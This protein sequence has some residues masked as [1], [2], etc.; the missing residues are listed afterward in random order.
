MSF[1]N[2]MYNKGIT[3]C[4]LLFISLMIILFPLTAHGG[5]ESVRVALR[6]DQIFT[7]NSSITGLNSIF[8]YEL[9]ALEE[10]SPLPSGAVN[11]KYAF[12]LEDTV[13]KELDPITYNHAG[14]YRYELRMKTP[15]PERGY[16]YDTQVYSIAVYVKRGVT[17]WLAEVTIHQQ[18]GIKVDGLKFEHSYTPL[19]S[20]RDVMVDPPV[21]KTVTGNPLFADTFTF[22]LTAGDI[23]NPMPEG[24]VDGVKKITITG[25][26]EKDFG[27]WVYTRE[28][29]Y[30]YKI[31]EEIPQARSLYVYD[32]A[33]Y[34][35][36]DSVKDVDRQ[37]V[38]TR[39]VTNGAGKQVESCIFINNYKGG[40]GS[41]VPGGGGGGSTKPTGSGVDGTSNIEDEKVP[42]GG[43]GES[44]AAI[45]ST[46]SEEAVLV[47]GNGEGMDSPKTGD[48]GKYKLYEVMLWSSITIAVGCI[49]YLILANRG[50]N[51]RNS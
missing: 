29:T 46:G 22:L 27:T 25:S 4:S 13:T 35:I 45:E 30:Y 9:T 42:L 11:G 8:S 31:S 38:V 50:K 40:G 16:A 5:A 41:P 48:D 3:V 2:R 34:T 14:I 33:I 17:D 1:I 7:K 43:A 36:T 28:G 18:D 21:Q 37:L 47:N 51:K 19:P 23:T 24:S 10:G 6:I 49:V 39:T 12:T 44:S 20:N 26:G 32:E 15:V